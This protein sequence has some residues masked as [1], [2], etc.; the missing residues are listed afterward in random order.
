MKRVIFFASIVL[1]VF[2]AP[3]FAQKVNTD[4]DKTFDFTAAKT[5]SWLPGH[6]AN[7]P[8]VH[9]RIVTAID[10]NLQA[11]GLQKVESNGDLLVE[12]AASTKEDI[13]ID[14]W[15]YGG[16]RWGGNR[17]VDINKIL[18]GMVVVDLIESKE[19]KLVWRGVGSD[20][21]SDNPEKNEKKIN[22]AA[23]KMFEKYPP[24]AK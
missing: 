13:Q 8:L 4:F 20:T 7:N 2:L 15:G 3:V 18:I 9:Q 1:M 24:K 22:N 19:K 17:T 23:K 16:W 10:T 11:K 5:Y 12:Y 14:E 21:V 6:P